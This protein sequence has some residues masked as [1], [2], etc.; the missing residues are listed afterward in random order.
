MPKE[1]GCLNPL[2]FKDLFEKLNFK[3]GKIV[4]FFVSKNKYLLTHHWI[5]RP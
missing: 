3:K 5:N 4:P 1:V 2:I